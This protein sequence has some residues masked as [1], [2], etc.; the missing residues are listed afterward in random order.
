[1]SEI[2]ICL[3][4]NL[5]EDTPRVKFYQH[6]PSFV[7]DNDEKTLNGIIQGQP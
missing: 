2:E 4:A 5:L 6:R 7:A 3:V 1:V